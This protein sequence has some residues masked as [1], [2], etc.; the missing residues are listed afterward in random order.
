LKH[1]LETLIFSKA[2]LE[3]DEEDEGDEETPLP[4]YTIEGGVDDNTIRLKVASDQ[5][6]D[7]RMPAYIGF[8][9]LRRLRRMFVER[10]R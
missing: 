5:P 6:L 8:V 1:V 10:I 4:R 9:G 3:G 2:H 7:F